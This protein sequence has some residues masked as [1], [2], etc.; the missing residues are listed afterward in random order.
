MAVLLAGANVVAVMLLDLGH[1][2][3]GVL[4]AVGN[5]LGNQ[6]VVTRGGGTCRAAGQPDQ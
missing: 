6:A 4:R 2:A 5:W 3:R 1:G